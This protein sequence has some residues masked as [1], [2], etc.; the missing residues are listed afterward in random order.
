M[1]GSTYRLSGGP[2]IKINKHYLF[3]KDKNNI[4]HVLSCPKTKKK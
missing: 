1:L 4:E 2:K 3:L